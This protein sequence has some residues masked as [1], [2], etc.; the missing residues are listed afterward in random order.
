MTP[1]RFWANVQKME[2][3]CWEWQRNLSPKGYGRLDV[4]G[5]TIGAHRMAYT[6]THGC[7]PDGKIIC[8]SCD[9]RRC[10][11]PDH[12]WAG[13]WSDNIRDMDAKGRRVKSVKL[14]ERH[15]A[16][17]LTEANV[18]YI[19]DLYASG[20]YTFKAIAEGYRVHKETIRAI[21]RNETW[22]HI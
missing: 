17:R 2:N 19:R 11:N 7:V 21:C 6:L 18:R 8:H 1:E 14:G 20:K 10:C 5:K 4:N 16:A 22:T 3:G 15:G 12:L 13:T 9:N